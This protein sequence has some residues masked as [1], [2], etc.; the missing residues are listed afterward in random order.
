MRPG[1]HHTR[2]LALAQPDPRIAARTVSEG[3]AEVLRDCCWPDRELVCVQALIQRARKL[4]LQRRGIGLVLPNPDDDSLRGYGQLTLWSRCAEIS[5]L[6]VVP[7]QRGLGLGTALIQHLC[8]HAYDLGV[9]CVEIGGAV[10]N[11]GALALYRSLG[12][13]DSYRVTLKLDGWSQP[14]IYLRLNFAD[15]RS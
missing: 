10:A 2:P 5:D 11:Q 14:V 1:E 12:F 6:I 4:Y 9:G 3:D 15:Y 7:A 8:L 13:E